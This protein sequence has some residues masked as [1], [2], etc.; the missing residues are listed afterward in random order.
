[1]PTL[2]AFANAACYSP[3]SSLRLLQCR[4]PSKPLSQSTTV[5]SPPTHLASVAANNSPSPLV[6]QLASPSTPMLLAFANVACYSPSSS[7]RLHR[8][9]L[10]SK[11]SSQSAIMIS[12]PTRLASAARQQLASTNVA[13]YSP[14]SSLRLLQC[15]SPSKPLSQS[16]TMISPPTRLTSTAHQQLTFS[17]TPTLLASANTACYSLSSSLCL[18]R[19][20][21]LSKPFSQSTTVISP[22][23][24]LALPLPLAS[25]LPPPLAKQLASPPTPMLLAFT[26]VT[27]YSPSNSFR[28]RMS[29]AKEASLTIHHNDLSTRLPLLCRS[30]LPTPLATHQAVHFTSVDAAHQA[31]CLC[32]NLLDL[33]KI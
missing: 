21:S 23:A 30:P 13:C 19:C 2:L 5:I 29:F 4:S 31:T 33:T 6:K 9:C 26:N 10:Q 28:L 22:P 25:S 12:P 8:C 3:S 16:S 20:R 17:P 32:R 1:M 7:L 24:R 15:C 18:C 11:P 27:C 14:S